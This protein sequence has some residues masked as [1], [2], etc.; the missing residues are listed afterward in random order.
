MTEVVEADRLIR[1]CFRNIPRN[2]AVLHWPAA[3]VLTLHA[4]AECICKESNVEK[5]AKQIGDAGPRSTCV[6]LQRA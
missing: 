4:S 6:Q 1:Q 3:P 2:C 5:A